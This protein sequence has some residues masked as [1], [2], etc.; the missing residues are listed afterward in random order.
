MHQRLDIQGLRAIAVILVIAFH[1]KLGLPQGY[2]GVDMFFVI[3]GYVISLSTIRNVR[4]EKRFN[5]QFF[6]RRRVRRLLPG[7]AIVAILSSIFALL[8]LSPFGPQQKT[9]TMLM[10]AATYSTNFALMKSNYYALD[11]ASNPLLHFWSL[12]V[13]EQF[14]FLWGP[15]VFAA[16]AI[17]GR[18]NRL[19][20]RVVLIICGILVAVGS[21][22]LFVLMVRYETTVI[23]WRGFRGLA[24]DGY[25]PSSFAFYSPV[26]RGWEFM[27]G[28]GIALVDSRTLRKNTQTALAHCMAMLGLALMIVGISNCF[29][30]W[31]SSTSHTAG[32]SP[33]AVI[34]TVVGISALLWAGNQRAF[35]NSFFALRPLTYIGDIS[36]TLYLWHWPIWVFGIA[37]FGRNN[38]VVSLGLLLTLLFS[39]V[40]YHFV[41]DPFRKGHLYP[42]G[43]VTK[44]VVAFLVV[45][46]VLM[47]GLNFSAS[48]IGVK[49]IGTTPE[50]LVRHVIDEPCPAQRV[51]I[52]EAST[53]RYRPKKADGLVILVGDSTAKSLSDGFVTAAH[54]LGLEAM[55]FHQAGCPFQVSD[56]PFNE[57]CTDGNKRNNDIWSAI[58]I[59]KP[60]AVVVSNLNFL[61]V[62]DIGFPD[63]PIGTT[64]VA[65][66]NETQKV[67]A[68]LQKLKIESLLVQPVP[69]FTSDVRYEV[70]ILKQL[71]NGEDQIV[72]NRG[73]EF[74]NQMDKN[75]VRKV[76]DDR[77]VLNLYRQFCTSDLCSRVIDGKF[78]YEDSTHL[79]SLGS[80]FIAPALEQALKLL[81]QN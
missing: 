26:T 53:C 8:A 25:F 43:T 72:L 64:R 54:N 30:V 41:E 79:S 31:D 1:Y 63:M 17:I 36:Y 65:W 73:N 66:A 76:F 70:S 50:Q 34:S 18:R 42:Q 47:V 74:L 6:Y 22:A 80:M 56:S 48:K 71:V 28:V 21:L 75:A 19:S 7:A 39:A 14:Y 35:T 55:V 4:S 33:W 62:R 81:V 68:Q 11:S 32:L 13:E 20:T 46:S 44:L 23:S 40:Q 52:G 12:A 16:V 2:L 61:Y 49:L 51:T 45:A 5:W 67:F 37:I 38:W 9:A 77:S 24:Q 15:V 3:S 27:A 57:F 78:M 10:S 59:L 60:V 58:R 69:E 29:G